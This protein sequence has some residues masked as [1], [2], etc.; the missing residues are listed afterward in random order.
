[1]SDIRHPFITERMERFAKLSTD[2]RAKI[3]FIHLNRTNP[4]IVPGSAAQ[5]AVRQAGLGLAREGERQDL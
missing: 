1:M 5:R 3:R 4:A 2:D